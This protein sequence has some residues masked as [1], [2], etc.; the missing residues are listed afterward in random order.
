MT[1][2]KESAP[3]RPEKKEEGFFRDLQ[4]EFL[5]HELKDPAAVIE[6]GVR[7]LLERRDKYGELNPLQEKTLKRILRNARKTRDMLYSLLEIGCTEAGRWVCRS[8]RPADLIYDC[9]METLENL[10][11]ETHAE[12]LEIDSRREALA[13]LATRGYEVDFSTATE[14]LFI[15]RDEEKFRLI[16]GNLLKNAFHFRQN[17]VSIKTATEKD[18]L[19]VTV[20][21]DGPGVRPEHRDLIFERYFRAAEQADSGRKGHG[22]GLAG[23]RIM[24]RGLGGDVAVD[25]RPEGGAV[26]TFRAPLLTRAE[27]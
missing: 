1:Q 23:A 4:V 16:I 10:E 2:I 8:F 21:D 14:G 20:A 25:N 5:I 24:A 22:L 9:L 7:S 3:V 15:W 6:S 18:D 26:F 11:E 19:V 17:L 13:F 27:D 12:A